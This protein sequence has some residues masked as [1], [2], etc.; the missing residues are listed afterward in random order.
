MSI[1]LSLPLSATTATGAATL[2]ATAADGRFG[3]G[4]G[5]W[6]F[7]MPLLWILLIGLFITAARRMGWRRQLR[8]GRLDAESVLRERYAR[9]E[10]DET[11]YR[12]RLEV[13]RGDQRR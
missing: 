6:F 3:H 7:L 2:A 10:V 12:Q 5:R 4:P 8:E 1:A 9:G 13:L 11:E